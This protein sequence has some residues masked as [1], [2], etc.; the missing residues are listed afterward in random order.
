MPAGTAELQILLRAR[1]QTSRAMGRARGG[2]QKLEK[3]AKLAFAA[4]A[5]GAAGAG[6][7]AL[8][9]AADF[10]K[11]MA[12]VATL[13]P[14][15]SD[16][17]FGQLQRDVLAFS[18]E[19]GIATDQVVPA[20]Y[21]AIS[22]GV[23][24]E[25]VMTFMQV[26]SRAAIGGVTELETAV[27]GITSVMNAYGQEVVSAQQAA[28]IM[29][30]G[31]KLGKTTFDELSQGLFQVIPTAATLGVT[32]QDITAALATTTAQGVPTRVATT[33]LRQALVEASKAGTDL[34]KAIRTI[35]GDSF[36]NLI[37]QGMTTIQ[38]LDGVRRETEAGGKAFGDLFGS[39][40]GMNAAL[41]ITGPNAAKTTEALRQMRDGAGA[42]NVAFDRIAATA[43]FKFQKAMNSLKIILLEVGLMILPTVT[44]VLGKVQ[45]A[46]DAVSKWFDAHK[47]TIKVFWESFAAGVQVTWDVLSWILSHKPIL[48]ATIFV[49]GMAIVAALGPVSGAALAIAG[50]VMLVGFL[51][52]HMGDVGD[53]ILAVFKGV[54]N[55]IIGY[56][57]LIIK[58][59][60]A[61]EF[62]LPSIGVG[63]FRTPAV[64]IG[65]PDIPPIPSFGQGGTVPGPMGSPQ[66]VMAHGGEKITPA[67]RGGG[68]TIV[69]NFPNYAGDKRDI[70][71]AVMGAMVRL[72]RKGRIS[73]VTT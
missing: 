50:I 48:V 7:A 20:L 42:S 61:L 37:K 68:D 22:A 44:V 5:I 63:K 71:D 21:Q 17:A 35:H 40:E 18:K 27:D 49:I 65:T 51:K 66:L 62:K 55:A 59:W 57:N 10:E 73:A 2:L 56:Y 64:T 23:P 29:F 25:N 1:D 4:V 24:R 31:V 9:M 36:A 58:I 34:D 32:F 43:S 26:A 70:E 19:M 46:L 54:A 11:G 12:E 60:N 38:I 69:F 72:E 45:Q 67:G 16:E 14:D 41:A 53:A 15:I 47:D 52:N 13:M 33:Q 3:A 6:V 8:K 28:D 30:T 39:V